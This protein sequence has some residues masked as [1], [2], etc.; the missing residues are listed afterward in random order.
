MCD[1]IVFVVKTV[2]EFVISMWW[3]A[4]THNNYQKHSYEEV[5]TISC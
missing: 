5:I 1:K 2:N 4:F 3:E